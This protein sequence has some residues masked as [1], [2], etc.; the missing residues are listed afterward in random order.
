MR[1]KISLL[2]NVFFS[3]IAIGLLYGC[4]GGA[5]VKEFNLVY[6]SPPEIPRIKY[7]KAYTGP[8]DFQQTKLLSSIILGGGGGLVTIVKPMGVHVDRFGRIHVADTAVGVVFVFDRKAMSF[9][10]ADITGRKRF[11]KPIGVASDANGNMF[12]TGVGN[13]KVS[14]FDRNGKYMMDIG[15]EAEFERPTGIA[16]DA[17]NNRV[18]VTDTTKCQ[19]FVFDLRTFKLIQTIGERGP[20]EGQF[21]LPAHIAV[22][23]TG[24]LYVSDTMNA[25]IQIFDKKGRFLLTFGEFGDGAGQFARPKGVAVDSEGHIYVV[26]AAFNNVQIFNQDGEVLMAFAGYGSGPGNIMLPAGIAIDHDDFIY[27]SDSWN[28]RINIYEF[29]GDKHKAREAAGIKLIK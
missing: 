16:V 26:D 6:P 11:K 19:V 1:N 15:E 20:N 27:V 2:K 25:R 7:I 28:E 17:I 18:Y 23:K 5:P 3:L 22:D 12:I 13:S 4:G 29:L 8:G 21:N 24:K 9:R 10:T 14:V